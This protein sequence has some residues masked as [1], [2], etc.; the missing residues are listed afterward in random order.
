MIKRIPTTISLYDGDKEKLEEIVLELECKS[1][2]AVLRKIALGEF[3]IV[4]ADSV[5]LSETEEESL[6]VPING[7]SS[8]LSILESLLES[9]LK[10]IRS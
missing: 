2:S 1:L 7:K 3:M 4:H 9:A 5:Q 6:V 10:I 8:K